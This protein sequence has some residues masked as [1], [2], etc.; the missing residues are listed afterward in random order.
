MIQIWITWYSWEAGYNLVTLPDLHNY[1]SI[2]F[3]ISIMNAQ[4]YSTNHLIM[5]LNEGSSTS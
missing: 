3:A 4:L 5:K 1:Q 2:Q